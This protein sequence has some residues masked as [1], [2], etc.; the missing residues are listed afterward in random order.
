MIRAPLINPLLLLLASQARAAVASPQGDSWQGLSEL[1][2]DT[3]D[4]DHT[5]ASWRQHWPQG[6]RQSFEAA[7]RHVLVG[8]DQLGHASQP[9]DI[10]QALAQE[11]SLPSDVCVLPWAIEG[12]RYHPALVDRV[13][14]AKIQGQQVWLDVPSTAV[15]QAAQDGLVRDGLRLGCAW[16]LRPPTEADQ[17]DLYVKALRQWTHQILNDP[18]FDQWVWPW[19][20]LVIKGMSAYASTGALPKRQG[21]PAGWPCGELRWPLLTRE[22]VQGLCN[23][24]G[25]EHVARDIFMG[26]I[27][28]FS[29]SQEGPADIQ[30]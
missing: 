13:V 1:C 25:N 16:F 27:S 15:I 30:G 23:H 18:S 9:C 29:S 19:A 21:A 17:Q 20:D 6:T 8:P 26:L 2:A 11:L 24:W 4:S 14:Q 28:A 10:A 5:L 12:R 3:A 7:R 22:V